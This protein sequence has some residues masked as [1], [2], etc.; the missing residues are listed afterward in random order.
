MGPSLVARL[1]HCV[2]PSHHALETAARPRPV[3][4]SRAGRL[5]PLARPPAEPIAAWGAVAR[6]GRHEGSGPAPGEQRPGRTVGVGPRGTPGGK[7]TG[8]SAWAPSRC[9]PRGTPAV[10]GQRPG[11]S[12]CG[13]GA[14]GPGGGSRGDVW[15]HAPA[16]LDCRWS[17]PEEGARA[18]PRRQHGHGPAAVL[19]RPRPAQGLAR[20]DRWGAQGPPDAGRGAEALGGPTRCRQALRERGARSGVGGLWP[21]RGAPWRRRCLGRK[22]GDLIAGGPRAGGPRGRPFRCP[23]DVGVSRGTRGAVAD[24]RGPGPQ[25]GHVPCSPLPQRPGCSGPGRVPGASLGGW[26][27]SP[28]VAPERG[29]VLAQCPPGGS[30]CRQP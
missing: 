28:G 15:R 12:H 20:R 7:P 21:P 30:R 13:T 8:V 3:P 24:G 16:G 29:L 22:G 11:G 17:R 18:T 10:G 4:L 6:L 23:P 1:G 19:A 25:S 26:A 27:S 5:A 2:V 14:H 9:P